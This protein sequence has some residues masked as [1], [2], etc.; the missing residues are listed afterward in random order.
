MRRWF[1]K[2]FRTLKRLKPRKIDLVLFGAVFTFLSG[3][4][5][6]Y[7][8]TRRG[9]DTQDIERI[10]LIIQDLET[11]AIKYWEEEP[12][13]PRALDLERKITMLWGRVGQS[14]YTLR[15]SSFSFRFKDK[16]KDK[17]TAFRQAVSSAPFGEYDRRPTRDR[18]E[19]IT[20]TANQLIAAV[21][22]SRKFL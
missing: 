6:T 17:I 1:Q 15:D 10:E 5:I 22:K 3:V 19:L 7:W 20:V 11:S 16:D 9:E 8:V 18:R 4:A 12:N 14:I 2:S 21:K 13:T